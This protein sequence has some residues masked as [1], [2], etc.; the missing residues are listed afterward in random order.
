MGVSGGPVNSS[1]R[2]DCEPADEASCGE[3]GSQTTK[4]VC[5]VADALAI[6]GDRYSLLIV[7]W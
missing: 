7:R 6:V 5:S 2:F 1:P 4:R 3:F